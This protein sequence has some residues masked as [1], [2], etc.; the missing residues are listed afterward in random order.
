MQTGERIWRIYTYGLKT[1]LVAQICIYMDFL[2]LPTSC[3]H[4]DVSIYSCTFEHAHHV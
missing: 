3:Q 2:T 4:S 1:V